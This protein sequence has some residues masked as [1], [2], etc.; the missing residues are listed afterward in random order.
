M[1]AYYGLARG[2]VRTNAPIVIDSP[3][4]LRL[5]LPPRGSLAPN[6]RVDPL[7]YYYA[8][9]IG[10][11][12]AARINLGLALLD[13]RYR[14]LLEIG[15]GSG[16]LLPTLARA[17]DVVDGI[18]L[19]SRPDEVRAALAKMR[20]T[21]G[22]LAQGDACALPFADARYDAVVAFSIL[23]HL[24]REQ[25]T[26]AIA[27]AHRVLSV[28]GRFLVGCPAVHTGMNV[29]FAAIGFRGIDQHHVSSIHDVLDVAKTHFTV[30]K[31][32]TLPRG[33]PLGWA[34]YGAVLLRKRG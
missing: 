22:E 2:F 5:A 1:A 8:P 19:A 3:A 7:K 30:E 9:L 24:R 25:L 27:E 14:R 16:L 32:A 11:V 34:P 4:V 20:V 6:N 23:E 10:R 17:A 18:D 12:F 21:V 29:A 31:R 15:Y 13:G 26:R 28:G 33:V